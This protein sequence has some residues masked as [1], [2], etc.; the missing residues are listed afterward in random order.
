M[1]ILFLLLFSTFLSAQQTLNEARVEEN[2]FALK[3]IGV[4]VLILVVMPFILRQLKSLTPKSVKHKPTIDLEDEETIKKNKCQKEEEEVTEIDPIAYGVEKLL[5]QRAIAADKHELFKPFYRKFVEIKMG[6]VDIKTGSFYID[7]VLN[8]VMKRVHSLDLERN[9]EVVFDMDANVPSQIIGDAERMEEILFYLIQN[10]VHE[11]D[12]YIVEVKI[13]RQD[14]GDAALHLEFHIAFNEDSK[15]IS[16]EA[17]EDKSTE[18]GLE[19]YLA[20]AYA[21]L[22]GGDISLEKGRGEERELVVKLKLYMPNPSEMRH[23]RLPSKTMIGHSV[24]IVDDHKESALAVQKMFEYFKNEVDLLSSK[25][26]FLALEIIDDYDIVVIQER[27]FAKHLLDRLEKNK[28]SSSVK[29]VS[30]NKNEAFSHDNARTIELLDGE[31][32]KP[33]TVQKVFDLLVSLYKV[34]KED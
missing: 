25:E 30:L 5:D 13:K 4:V 31:I 16:F 34:E 9:F 17:F 3:I 11:S 27:Y 33:V 24:M 14:F 21:K 19:L 18:T 2:L 7:S 28:L 10:V 29:V 12:I 20:K 8:A 15:K 22:M 1:H 32:S 23:Y 26:L 6:T